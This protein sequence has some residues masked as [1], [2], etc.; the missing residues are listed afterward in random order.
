MNQ[1]PDRPPP[2]PKELYPDAEKV[3]K[4]I[5]KQE[6]KSNLPRILIPIFIILLI[7][8]GIYYLYRSDIF[9]SNKDIVSKQVS[10]DLVISDLSRFRTVAGHFYNTYHTFEELDQDL[11]F[12]NIANDVENHGSILIVTGLTDKTFVAY[13]L[14]PTSQKY[15]CTDAKNFLGIIESVDNIET[16]CL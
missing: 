4:N 7:S 6:R 15:Y 12:K 9:Q 10:D 14:L 16:T 3:S 2:D 11:D 1:K 5:F 13:V 8:G